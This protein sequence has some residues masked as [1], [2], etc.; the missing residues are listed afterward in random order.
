MTPSDLDR[1]G[2]LGQLLKKGDTGTVRVETRV[3][4]DVDDVWSA[5]TDPEKLG[6]WYGDV[7]GDLRH[8]GE[9]R[10][11]LEADGWD[12]GGRIEVCEP[13]RHLVV[14]TRESDESW[15]RGNGAPPFDDRI[16]AILTADGSQTLL[17]IEISGLPINVI[18]FY[19]VG[20]QIHMENLV[21]HLAGRDPGDTEPRW[22][23]LLP[24][25]QGLAADLA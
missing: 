7:E 13:A 4:A 19:G 2:I 9:F 11:H 18:A 15:R 25:Y 1:N 3:D 16:E 8:G 5:L 12:G 20:W 23:E 10:L 21:N 17:V 24:G 22:A 6:R 14:T